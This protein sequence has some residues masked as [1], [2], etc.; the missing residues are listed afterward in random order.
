MKIAVIGIGVMGSAIAHRLIEQQCDVY[1]HDKSQD[2]ISALAAMGA[3]AAASAEAAVAAC[4]FVIT[5]L[6]TADIVESVVFGDDGFVSVGSS[7]KLLIDMSSIDAGRTAQM[8]ER[9]RRDCGMGWVDAPL[10]GGAPAA[11][12]GELTLMVG[13]DEQDVER[14]RSVL[15]FLSKNITHFGAPGAGQTVKSI[16]QVLCAASFL[17][18]AEAVRFAEAH[19]VD[20]AM[21]PAALAGGRADSRILQEFMAKMAHRDYSPTGRIDNMLKDLETVQAASLARRIPMP[22]TSMIADL[23]RMLVAGGFG[24]ADSAEYMRLFDLAAGSRV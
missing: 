13:G 6:N 9:L 2:R 22:V 8:A 14:A 17:A 5:S 23:H 7:E 16:N 18:V 4:D 3:T 11:A 20:A 21:I 10:S 15:S 1:V 19:G 24:P 12:R